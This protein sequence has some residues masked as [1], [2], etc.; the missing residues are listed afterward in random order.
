[1][2]PIEK[3]EVHRRGL[4]HKAISIFV[5]CGGKLLI[6]QRASNKYHSPELWANSCCSHPNWG[7]NSED[8]SNRRIFEELGLKNLELRFIDQIEYKANVGSELIEHEVVDC[9]S[10]LCQTTP[11]IKMNPEEVK[12]YAWADIEQLRQDVKQSPTKYTQWFKIYLNEHFEKLF[13]CQ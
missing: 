3:L 11:K 4:K 10:A 6:Q 2:E 5:F 9:F 1:L 7:E 8:C 12:N 13:V